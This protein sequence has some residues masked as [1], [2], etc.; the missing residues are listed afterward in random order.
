VRATRDRVLLVAGAASVVVGALLL[1]APGAV[2]L[3]PLD[4]LTDVD[5]ATQV[6]LLVG[7]VVAV[8]AA[9]QMRTT[10][11]ET[12][13]RSDLLPDPPERARDA[14]VPAPGASLAET[15]RRLGGNIDRFGRD[16]WHVVAYGRRARDVI[17][18]PEE[19]ETPPDADHQRAPAGPRQSGQQGPVETPPGADRQRVSAGRLPLGQRGPAELL[20]LLDDVAA[21]ARDTYATATDC[22]E[23]TA[24]RAVETGAWTDDRLAAAFLATD[25]DG[26]TFTVTERALAWLTPERTLDRRLD[27]TLAAIESHA[28]GF[29]TYRP[30][31]KDGSHRDDATRR[32]DERSD[33][34]PARPPERQQG[35]ETA[36][37]GPPASG[38]E[39]EGKR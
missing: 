37:N 10:A 5:T 13:D 34:P 15:Y 4:P 25:H 24:G 16:G 11:R 20:E 18:L 32:T 6:G 22:D 36:S 2:P 35:G 7:F 39:R 14:P 19:A 27:R 8:L 21:T 12:L 33:G 1:L 31:A 38:P 9:V 28:E 26:P 3:G 29:L 17:D 30:P 23:A